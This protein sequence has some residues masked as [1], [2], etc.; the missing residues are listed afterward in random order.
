MQLSLDRW[1]DAASIA[2]GMV[3]AREGR[4][5][6]L[7]DAGPKGYLAA[8][9]SGSHGEVYEVQISLGFDGTLRLKRLEANIVV[10][11][12][13]FADVACHF[14]AV[15]GNEQ[16]LGVLGRHQF[17]FPQGEKRGRQDQ[18]ARDQ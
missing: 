12:V 15:S 3:Y 6:G 7:S 4:V 10:E 1:F 13:D 14:V 17:Q 9:V 2:R 16:P 18:H 11:S 5:V 8:K